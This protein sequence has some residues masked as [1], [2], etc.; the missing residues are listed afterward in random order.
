MRVFIG[1]IVRSGHLRAAGEL[2]CIDWDAKRV[3]NAVAI[4]P[5]NP[6]FENDPNPRGNTRGVRGIECYGQHVIAADYHSLR[7]FDHELRPQR[8]LT[9]DL[10]V[11]LHETYCD[12]GGTIWV[13]S[14]AIDAALR[15]DLESAEL[16]E[17]F[18]PREMSTFQRALDLEPLEIDKS[19]DNRS[20]FI[21]GT[22]LNNPSHLHLNA[23]AEWRGE[24][25]AL[26]NAFG[27]IANL[28]RGEIAIRDPRIRLGHN[29]VILED[30]TTFVSDTHGPAVCIFDLVSRQLVS[31]FDLR[32][33][34][35]ARTLE[36]LARLTNLAR[37]ST[38]KAN[39]LGTSISKPLFTRGLVVVGDFVFSAFA[40]AT[41]VCL[42]WKT[43]EYLDHFTYSRNVDVAI[44]GLAVL[45]D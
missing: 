7:F 3:S 19:V 9:H 6:S 28:S 23:V 43:G 5:Q 34:P 13:T 24:V 22:H 11:G 17:E 33:I 40:P 21:E 1:T 29:L 36:R 39:L 18:W 42:N 10:M 26:F 14:T 25:Y 2:V 31:A 8:T 41:V 32:E 38:L 35:V 12:G 16:L 45:P 4:S 20:L 30:G 44:H 15:Y 37:G 27:A